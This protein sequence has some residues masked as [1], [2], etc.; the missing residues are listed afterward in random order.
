MSVTS[1]TTTRITTIDE[2][3]PFA[4]AW[5]RL[6]DGNP[7]RSWQWLSTWW[8]HYQIA[9]RELYV[10]TVHSH[11]NELVGVLPLYLEQKAARG[12]VLRLLGSGEVCSDHLTVLTTREHE[13]TV[14]ESI[15]NHLLERCS[16]DAEDHDLWDLLELDGIST[17]DPAIA[18]LVAVLSDAGCGM[19]RKPGLNCW[20]VTLPATWNEL[21]EGLSKNRR[22]VLRRLQRQTIDSA[23]GVFRTA[24]N[25]QEFEAAMKQ[26][27]D[28]HQRRR[29]SLGEPGCFASQP[30]SDF[31]HDVSRKLWLAGHLELAWFELDGQLV[32]IEYNLLGT[33]AVYSYQSG[34]DPEALDS[35]PGHLLTMASIR[36]SI[37]QGRQTY[38][39][40]RGDEPYKSHWNAEPQATVTLQVSANRTSAQVRQGVWLAGATMKNWVKG[41]LTLTGMQ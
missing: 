36:N 18:K 30:F 2:L 26:F 31:I 37:E 15:A 10:I 22:K 38:D 40:L 39:F 20:N 21:Y 4:P 3:R 6:A 8:E 35:S 29:I 9:G 12:R 7:F 27:V 28:L 19:H 17:N 41:G 23:R 14:I 5:N 13:D 1:V 32:A 11:T 34:V 25:D 24:G 33:D 16:R